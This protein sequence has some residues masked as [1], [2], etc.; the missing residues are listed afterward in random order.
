MDYVAATNLISWVPAQNNL[1][2]WPNDSHDAKQV[3]G[4]RLGEIVVP[5]FSQAPLYTGDFDQQAYVETICAT[6][7]DDYDARRAEYE[8]IVSG[9][10]G[11]VPFVMRVTGPSRLTDEVVSGYQWY[12]VPIERLVL[13]RPI[14][15]REFLRLR[16][17]PRE[18]AG[19][20]KAMAA[21]GRR[22]QALG[23]GAGARILKIGM[24]QERGADVLRTETLV[25]AEDP[26]SAD[27]ALTDAGLTVRVGDR[28]FLALPDRIPG[29]VG[30][31][32]DGTL[33][34]AGSAIAMAPA[35]LRDLFT[36]AK[37]AN[38]SF[39]SQR[40]IHAA[41]ELSA[42]LDSG[43]QVL[44]VPDFG[45]FHDRY[46]LLAAKVTE[47]LDT[48]A[49][50]AAAGPGPDTSPPA[51]EPDEPEEGAEE[52][53]IHLV[54]GLS[55]AAVRDALPDGMAIDDRVLA[56]A[57]T[58]LRAGKHLLLAGPPG[59]GKSTLAAAICKAAGTAYRTATATADW[60]TVDT[61]GAYLPDGAG[62]LTFE[63]GV[64]LQCLDEGAWLIIDEINRADIDKAFGPMFSLL[65][66]T[67]GHTGTI[68]LPYRRDGKRIEIGW[69][70]TLL[71]RTTNYAVTP[72]WRMIG[73]LN[74]SDKSSLFTL[75]FAFLR[76]FA[77]VD[78][79]L[80]ASASYGEL[81]GSRLPVN[82]PAEER[83]RLKTAALT[84]ATG[85][86]A[87]G[88]AIMLDVAG[89]T[90]RGIT[91]N[92]AGVTPYA[93]VVDAFLVALRLYIAPQYEG[94]T[95]EQVDGLLEMVRGVWREPPAKPFEELRR[96][97]RRGMLAG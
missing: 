3:A 29:L 5:K 14:S 67:G 87:L 7:G 25:R 43:E 54:E 78:V 62:S 57:A 18:I 12:I 77:V 60:T 31:Q 21:P 72:G 59:T 76:R 96:A 95:E 22:V 44:P 93:D 71:A 20:F 53:L 41:D 90:R 84:V 28:A 61:I 79:G 68:T 47:A 46:V 94:A 40:A 74:D 16:V 88:P 11:A 8:S 64:V 81:I 19:Q 75:S 63:E 9:G 85:P 45:H 4:L 34:L 69:A 10:A 49:A 97:L 50:Q 65:A 23:I 32:E 1:F 82:I 36:R 73:T 35:E 38:P 91:E 2:G 33:E 92:A 80:P 13:D 55:A 26:E 83:D 37:A 30:A 17:V 66:G 6:F 27:A 70:P 52:A 51:A 42:F 48:L 39:R 56:E 24:M 89:F 15:T 58:A 86:V